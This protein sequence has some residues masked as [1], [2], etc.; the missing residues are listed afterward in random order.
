MKSIQAICSFLSMIVIFSCSNDDSNGSSI[1]DPNDI[2]LNNYITQCNDGV[3]TITG[4]KAAYWDNA[5]GIPLPL[6]QIPLLENTQGQ[7]IHSAYPALGFPL[8]QGYSGIEVYD[9]FSGLIGVNVIRNDDS[10]VVWRYVP[11]RAFT[12]PFTPDDAMAIEINDMLNHY[13]YDGSGLNVECSETVPVNL[14]GGITRTFNAR[15]LSFQNTT[16]L[17]YVIVTTVQGLEDISYVTSSVSS[18]PTTEYNSLVGDIFLPLN[19][20][21]LVNDNGLID[22]DLDGTPDENDPAPNNPDIP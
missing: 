3:T 7:F 14:G 9:Q 17:V 18:G 6:V 21:L 13:N 12:G 10:N 16:A 22:S 1:T 5:K 19:F 20:Q 2:I 8:P 11:T 15:L 4:A